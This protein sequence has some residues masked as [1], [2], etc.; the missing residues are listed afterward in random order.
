MNVN[1]AVLLASITS[2]KQIGTMLYCIDETL[3]AATHVRVNQNNLLCITQN[4][5]QVPSQL[6]FGLDE[7][8]GLRTQLPTIVL[9][10]LVEW[11]QDGVDDFRE[12]NVLIGGNN[13]LEW[14]TR[15]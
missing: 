11:D 2:A 7:S 3:L 6:I 8:C 1:Q 12:L 14:I 10:S 5:L 9:Q 4:W 13:T 15:I